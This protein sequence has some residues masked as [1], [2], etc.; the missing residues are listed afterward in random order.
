MGVLDSVTRH[1]S[2][3]FN[4]H[5]GCAL[6]RY[7]LRLLDLQIQSFHLI[8]MGFFWADTE[9]DS[10]ASQKVED[11]QQCHEC[12]EA[13]RKCDGNNPCAHCT[14]LNLDCRPYEDRSRV[15]HEKN[16]SPTSNDNLLPKGIPP[17]TPAERVDL[18][19]H[20]IRP[21]GYS[22][23]AASLVSSRHP[24][25]Y[26]DSTIFDDTGITTGSTRNGGSLSTGRYDPVESESGSTT[27]T[28]DRSVRP[29]PSTSEGKP[30]SEFSKGGGRPFSF[31]MQFMQFMQ[32]STTSTTTSHPNSE[33]AHDATEKTFRNT[34]IKGRNFPSG[35]RIIDCELSSCN[36]TDLNIIHSSFASC[37]FSGSTVTDCKFS[38]SNLSSCTVRDCS[39]ST[40]NVVGGTVRHC[41][42]WSST[43]EGKGAERQGRSRRKEETVVQL[44]DLEPEAACMISIVVLFATA[45]CFLVVFD[46]WLDAKR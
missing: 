34:T 25:T 32:I 22:S 10:V 33:A 16:S 17:F 31:Q 28:D 41:S 7:P 39:F 11:A 12:H 15:S 45:A 40:S 5:S 9:E 37:N 19:N 20:V 26:S 42:H 43:V 2:K 46:R 24:D 36:G 44:S 14:R 1:L 3:A 6:R 18:S 8:N 30:P 35:A 38:S 13:Q 29:E 27:G 4:Q 23:N 21:N